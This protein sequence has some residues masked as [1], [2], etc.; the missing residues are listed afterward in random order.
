MNVA[1]NQAHSTYK[2]LSS[3]LETVYGVA[4]LAADPTTILWA[5]ERLMKA[6]GMEVALSQLSALNRRRD[7]VG[8]IPAYPALGSSLYEAWLN[9]PK[10]VN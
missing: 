1:T 5:V 2:G 7:R 8:K 10:G 3:I 6:E 4:V 9:P